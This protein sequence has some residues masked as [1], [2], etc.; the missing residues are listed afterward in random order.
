M[1]VTPKTIKGSATVCRCFSSKKC[2]I[3]A[4]SI[5]CSIRSR[6]MFAKGSQDPRAQ[7]N[8]LTRELRGG[9]SEREAEFA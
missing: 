6:T 4:M 8:R 9:Q 1:A 7:E 3:Q 2:L 5:T